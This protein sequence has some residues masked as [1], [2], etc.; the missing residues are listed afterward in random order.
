MECDVCASRKQ[1]DRQQSS[2]HLERHDRSGRRQRDFGFI[3][4]GIGR[5]PARFALNNNAC[6]S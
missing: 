1:R 3:G 4:N 2:Q 5:V 6:E